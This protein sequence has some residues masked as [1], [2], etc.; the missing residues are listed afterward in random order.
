MNN[1]IEVIGGGNWAT[2]IVKMLC[3]NCMDIGWWMRDKEQVHH[4][5]KYGHNPKYLTG[6]ELD[7]DNIKPSTDLKDVI[8][9]AEILIVETPS[10][11]IHDKFKGM[12]LK[13]KKIVSAVKGI[14]PQTNEI[15]ADYYQNSSSLNL[16]DFAII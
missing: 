2:A 5:L 3:N 12:D 4:I 9:C 13:G 10:A 6:A 1:K 11:F 8:G 14:I 7:S 15:P 16:D